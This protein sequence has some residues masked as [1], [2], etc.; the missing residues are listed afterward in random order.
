L[1][2]I[3]ISYDLPELLLFLP[4]E[5]LDLLVLLLDALYV[6]L[7]LGYDLLP[8]VLLLLLLLLLGLLP[9]LVL[10]LLEACQ[11]F[12]IDPALDDSLLTSLRGD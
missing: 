7:L 2:I 5:H 11:E 9:P 4:L 3:V 8:L 6:P 12:P 1:L 10:P